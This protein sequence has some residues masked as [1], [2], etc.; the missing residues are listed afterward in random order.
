MTAKNIVTQIIRASGL[1][2]EE[3]IRAVLRPAIECILEG[4]PVGIPT[5]TVYGLA[6]N[7]LDPEAASQ[8]F[9]IKGRPR[10]NPLIV[11]IS[12]LAQLSLLTTLDLMEPKSPLEKRLQVII[13][14]S[15]LALLLCCF[16]SS[17]SFQTLSPVV[18]QL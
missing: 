12:S 9:A 14:N 1:V 5:E 3:E 7:A 17:P 13:E 16:R 18:F 10:D 2:A 4:K 6:A 15:G 11:H 8:I